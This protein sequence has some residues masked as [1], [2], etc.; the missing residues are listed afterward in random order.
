MATQ[1][2]LDDVVAK[3]EADAAANDNAGEAIVGVLVSVK[4]LYDDAIAQ[5]G[6]PQ[7]ALDRLNAVSAKVEARAQA[8]SDAAI[9]NTPAAPSSG[10]GTVVP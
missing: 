7:E 4:K 1:Q 3:I 5:G 9:A 2:E 6:I 10:D 8:L